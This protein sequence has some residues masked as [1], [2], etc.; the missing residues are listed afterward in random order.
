MKKT[1]YLL[2]LLFT[3]SLVWSQPA[4]SNPDKREEMLQSLRIAYITKQLDLTPGEAEKFWPVYNKYQGDLRRIVAEHR[5][6]SG[7]ELEL[8]ERVLNLR[9]QYRAEFLGCISEQKFN[10]LLQAEAGWGD[11]LRKEL[12]RRRE[13]GERPLMDRRMRRPGGRGAE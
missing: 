1:F 5:E 8:Q 13:A 12:Q 11:M 10:R 3:N 7:N 4:A 2:V 9:K 6:K